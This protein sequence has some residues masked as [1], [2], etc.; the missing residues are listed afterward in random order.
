MSTMSKAEKEAYKNTTNVAEKE[1]I[2]DN[3]RYLEMQMNK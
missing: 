1:P 3:I 2:P